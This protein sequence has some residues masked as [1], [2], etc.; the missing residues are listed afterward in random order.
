MT[1]DTITT[2]S[3]RIFHIQIFSICVFVSVGLLYTF[4][5]AK[6]ATP[7]FANHHDNL[8]TIHTDQIPDHALETHKNGAKHAVLSLTNHQDSSMVKCADID[9]IQVDM[10]QTTTNFTGSFFS[11]PLSN[12][13]NDNRNFYSYLR[14]YALNVDDEDLPQ[15][16]TIGE[17]INEFIIDIAHIRLNY[18]IHATSGS[19][20]TLLPAFGMYGNTTFWPDYTTAMQLDDDLCFC[21]KRNGVNLTKDFWNS[22]RKEKEIRYLK[23]VLISGEFVDNFW[24]S[25]TFVDAM[26]RHKD[27]SD[28][29]FLFSSKKTGIPK[30]IKSFANAFGVSVVVHDQPIVSEEI[31]TS[32]L[33]MGDMPWQQREKTSVQ[34]DWSCIHEHFATDGVEQDSILFI[35]RPGSNLSRDIPK[36]IHDKLVNATSEAIPALKMVTFDGS[37]T[38]YKTIEKFQSAKIVVGP[39][40]AAMTNLVFSQEGTHVIEYLTPSLIY[41]Q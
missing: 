8:A 36:S 22:F 28:L 11:H 16:K 6:P 15:F 3:N 5:V 33:P 41:P 38:F 7:S 13:S 31:K 17:D 9:S 10:T 26:C 35:L 27:D 1:M 25:M 19:N 20:I 29:Y 32:D 23:R 14:N 34:Q 12:F 37:E 18:T 4:N 24:H 39:H 2:G 30:W 40:G 21:P